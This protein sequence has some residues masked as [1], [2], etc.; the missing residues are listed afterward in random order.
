MA[1]ARMDV[2]LTKDGVLHQPS[3][4]QA[5][6]NGLTN[7]TDL[8]VVAHGWNNDMAEARALY[9]ELL[10]NVDKLLDARDNPAAP[11]PLARLRGR[12]FAACQL[13]WPSKKFADEDLIPGGGAAS[14]TAANDSA[15]LR[16]LD[17]LAR[18]PTR[19]GDTSSIPVRQQLAAKAKALVPRLD[20]DDTA[21]TEFVFILRS[22][23]DPDHAS[24]DDGSDD[25]FTV[26]PLVL[27]KDMDGEVVAPLPAG[28]GGATAL[29][30]A[31]GAAG[32]GDLLGGAKAAARR[33]AN[34]A[35][36][37][38][39]KARAGTVATAGV[40]PLLRRVRERAPNVRLHLAGHSFGG[41]LVTAAAHA[42]DGGT[43]A[44][45]VSLLQAA[46]SH[47][48]LSEDFGDG[49]PGFF[50]QVLSEKR[51]S[52]PIVITHTKND[53]AVGIAYPL[54]SRI[55]RQNAA[56]FGDA[57]DP[58]GGMGRNGAQRTAEAAGNAVSLEGVGHDYGF[59]RGKVYNLLSDATI[60]DH[61]DVRG[62]Q[63]A[64]AI[65]SAAGAV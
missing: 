54:A 56:A 42:L 60:K 30:A 15:L 64:Y 35:T 22:L 45:S 46:F 2:E 10:G 43:P 65:L 37:Y 7:V 58:Y 8:I 1:M 11:A 38:Q 25:F 20:A 47:N 26:D 27:F 24:R 63:V 23:L 34:F 33:L 4:V 29:G 17:G 50:R 51:A 12:T 9:D 13:F 59:A 6:L 55:A 52:G 44:V 19:L 21:R 41:R 3:Q 14:A 57:N 16:I 62:I 31:G 36:Y 39:M 18:E 49:Q 5:L 61:S 40:A 53:R 32:L 28:Q 48:G